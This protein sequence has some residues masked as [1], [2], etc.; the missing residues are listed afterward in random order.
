MYRPSLESQKEGVKVEDSSYIYVYLK[1]CRVPR[2]VPCRVP[3]GEMI[4][5]SEAKSKAKR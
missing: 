1:C 4:G 5:G 2:R 3:A